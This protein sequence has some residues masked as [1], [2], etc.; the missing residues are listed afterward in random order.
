M[1][2]V[3]TLASVDCVEG[4]DGVEFV[5]EVFVAPGEEVGGAVD[6]V[7]REISGV[8]ALCEAVA[9]VEVRRIS[10]GRRCNVGVFEVLRGVSRGAGVAAR[11][12]VLWG[13]GPEA[14][15][16]VCREVGEIAGGLGWAVI[17]G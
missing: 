3:S 4:L 10:A 9:E 5:C 8:S 1:E 16:W 7:L 17:K 13:R 12:D 6:L 15:V 11:E 2:V 14:D